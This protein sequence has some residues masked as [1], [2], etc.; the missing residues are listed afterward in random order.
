MFL[1][2]HIRPRHVAA[3]CS[4]CIRLRWVAAGGHT[5]QPVAVCY[6]RHHHI[7]AHCS[8]VQFVTVKCSWSQQGPLFCCVQVVA[9]CQQPAAR[10]PQADARSKQ[11]MQAARRPK[12]TARRPPHT[13]CKANRCKAHMRKHSNWG[14]SGNRGV[15]KAAAV[16]RPS[17]KHTDQHI[18]RLPN[19]THTRVA[20]LC[21]R[22]LDAMMAALTMPTARRMQ[23][24]CGNVRVAAHRC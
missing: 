2:C 9:F 18:V 11:P 8:R 13:N 24:A 16:V 10:S 15:G 7:A 5:L 12:A 4:S 6:S 23:G 22:T 14:A 19:H 17:N 20:L 3:W 21:G 1:C